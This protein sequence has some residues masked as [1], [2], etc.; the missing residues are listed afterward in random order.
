[1]E[2]SDLMASSGGTAGGLYA[3]Y[4][5]ERLLVSFLEKRNGNGKPK[6]PCSS[7]VA[8]QLE[9]AGNAIERGAELTDRVF[10]KIVHVET[11]VD[12]VLDR[13]EREVIEGIKDIKNDIKEG[14]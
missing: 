11:K 6:S 7:Q 9:R 8:I 14:S 12:L 4:R 5:I 3:L 1:M 2:V 13:I 10:D